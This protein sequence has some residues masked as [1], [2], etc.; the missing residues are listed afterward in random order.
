MWDY[1]SVLLILTGLNALLALGFNLILGYGGLLS[2]AQPMLYAVGA[3]TAAL[4]TL[5]GGVPVW[6]AIPL[7]GG[8]AVL[9]SLLL[10]LPSLRVSGDYFVLASLAAQLGVLQVISNLDVTGGPAGLGGMPALVAGGA[11]AVLA[12]LILCVLVVVVVGLLALVMRGGYGRMVTA[13][14]DDEE[15]VLALGRNT[16]RI[17]VSL[18][19]VGSGI[20]GIAGGLYAHVFQYVTP[21]QFDITSSTAMLTMVVVGGSATIWGPVIG[22]AILTVL[23][24]ALTFLAL[25]E[26]VAG[27][28]QGIIYTLLVLGF[29]FLRP[30]G[31]LGSPA[32]AASWGGRPQVRWSWSSRTPASASVASRLRATSAS[33]STP[34]RSWG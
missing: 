18:F 10:S 27:P 34:G 20:A 26:A 3:Y 5:H 12:P 30:Q 11:R 32:G 31:I 4:L 6:L 17:K 33:R 14:R 21:A 9:A 24:Q 1:L 19:A 13:M 29:L 23:P 2:V 8:A 15:A 28:L 16:R 22:A 7:G 25:P